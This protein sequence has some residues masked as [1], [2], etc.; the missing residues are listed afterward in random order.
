MQSL[1]ST[2]FSLNG[3]RISR[4]PL[5]AEA[6]RPDPVDL[7]TRILLRSSAHYYREPFADVC[8]SDFLWGTSIQSACH[9]VE[10]RV[11]N[12]A[13]SDDVLTRAL[14]LGV[15]DSNQPQV[16]RSACDRF[17]LLLMTPLFLGFHRSYAPCR[18]Y[19]GASSDS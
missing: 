18:S 12:I 14:E 10:R 15:Y 8:L 19:R 11:H 16:R 5:L 1:S 2:I 9:M 17:G 13:N 4:H 7:Q 3:R 6:H